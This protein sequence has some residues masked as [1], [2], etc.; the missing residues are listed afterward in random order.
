MPKPEI[1]GPYPRKELREGWLA[2]FRQIFEEQYR[3]RPWS[4]VRFKAKNKAT[5]GTRG[6]LQS[7]LAD[8]LE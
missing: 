6:R 2:E 8:H 4:Y 1:P 7:S 5:W 3:Q